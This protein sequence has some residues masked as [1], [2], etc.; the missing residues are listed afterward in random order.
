MPQASFNSLVV[1]AAAAVVS[2]FQY[3]KRWQL[4]LVASIVVSG[5]M[6]RYFAVGSSSTRASFNTSL[7]VD[8][9]RLNRLIRR[10][11]TRR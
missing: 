8:E 4:A 3:H 9:K 2:F 11:R 5:R 1:V 7:F 6:N 10:G